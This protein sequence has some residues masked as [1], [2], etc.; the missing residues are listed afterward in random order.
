LRHRRLLGF[1]LLAGAVVLAVGVCLLWPGPSAISQE[2]FE[3]IQV[4]M[5]LTEVEAIM[6]QKANVEETGNWI[7]NA[8]A[9]PGETTHVWASPSDGLILVVSQNDRVAFKRFSPAAEMTIM[10]RIGIWLTIR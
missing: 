3:K 9:K 6:G 5:V 4:G 8:P 1:G 2:N 10:Q 7:S